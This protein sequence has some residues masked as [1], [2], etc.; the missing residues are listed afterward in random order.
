MSDTAEV[1]TKPDHWNVL[2]Q[3]LAVFGEHYLT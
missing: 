1:K 2:Q 3:A